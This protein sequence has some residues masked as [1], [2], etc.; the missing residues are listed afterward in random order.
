MPCPAV[1]RGWSGY[2]KEFFSLAG[3]DIPAWLWGYELTS[4]FSVR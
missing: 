3:V 1:A 2:V 4:F